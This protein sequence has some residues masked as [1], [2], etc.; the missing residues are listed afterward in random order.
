M[1]VE[2]IGGVVPERVFKVVLEGQGCGVIHS[3]IHQ[4]IHSF[5]HSFISLSIHALVY[6]FI[7]SFIR[8]ITEE[9]NVNFDKYFSSQGSNFSCFKIKRSFNNYSWV[10]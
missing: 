8:L 4:T 2:G 6:S 5:M 1:G 3:F 7:H 9:F 10:P